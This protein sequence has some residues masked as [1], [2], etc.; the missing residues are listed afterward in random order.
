MGQISK[1]LETAR[2]RGKT[3]HLPY[4]GE[5]LPD[6]AYQ[7]MQSAPGA[8]LLDVRTKAEC[9]WVG[10]VPGAIEIEWVTYPGMNRN[11][12]FQ[13]SLEQQIDKEALLMIIC[14]SGIRSHHAATVAAQAGYTEVF[15]V[16]E[17]FEGDKDVE[18]HRNILNGWR[19][20]RLP[21]TQS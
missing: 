13:T 4:S 14:R 12:N 5:L 17:G 21:W 16:V 11:P 7:L 9:D 20:A 19:A 3:K 1:I 15:S 10:R 18:E 8:K 2:Q 6:E